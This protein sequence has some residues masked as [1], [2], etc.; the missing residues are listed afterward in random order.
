MPE[1]REQLAER[2]VVV[3]ERSATLTVSIGAAEFP[4][5]GHSPESLIGSADAALYQA[6]RSGRDRAVRV[7]RRRKTTAAKPPKSAK[8]K[9]P[10]AS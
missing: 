5:D 1:I 3:G 9:K 10:D 4:T 2:S 8:R 6:K 7:S